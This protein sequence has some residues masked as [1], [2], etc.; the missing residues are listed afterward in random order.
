MRVKN[1][2]HK[3]MQ[4]KTYY[5]QENKQLLIDGYINKVMFIYD[6]YSN[7]R[8]RNIRN[9]VKFNDYFA[10]LAS[11]LN[12]IKGDYEEAKKAENIISANKNNLKRL[13]DLKKDLLYLQDNFVI[14][15]KTPEAYVRNFKR[16]KSN[17]NI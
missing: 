7:L 13:N 6:K 1:A 2:N 10:T 15:K 9:H 5:I 4:L 16:K 11:V 14:T 8:R 3:T 12:C 17:Q